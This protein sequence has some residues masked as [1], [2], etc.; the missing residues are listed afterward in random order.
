MRTSRMIVYSAAAM[1][2]IAFLIAVWPSGDGDGDGTTAASGGTRIVFTRDD[3]FK[4]MAVRVLPGTTIVWRNT[5]RNPHTA[6]ADDMSWDTG[7]LNPGDEWSMTFNEP[8][9]YSYFCAYH[10]A[11]G[12]HGMAGVI[13]VGDVEDEEHEADAFPEPPPPGTGKTIRVPDDAETIQGAVDQAEPG[14]LILVG[15][16]V[17]HEEVTVTTPF[18]TIRGLDRNEVILDGKA[19]LHNGIKVLGAPGVVI[20][21][22]TARYY[23]SNGFYWTGVLGYRGS[24]LT[25]YN[26]GDYGIYAFG[27]VYGQFDNSYASGSPDSGFYIGQCKPCHALITDVIAEHNALGYSG[28]NAG[29]NLTIMNSVWRYN[30]SGIVPNTLDSQRLA[31]QDGTRIV[32]NDIYSNHNEEAPTFPLQYPSFGNGIVLTG[33]INNVVEGN[34]IWD[35]PNYGIL[36]VPNIDEHFWVSSGHTIRANTLWDSGKADLAMALPTGADTCFEENRHTSSLPG[37][38]EAVYSCGAP[39][40]KLGGGDPAVTLFMLSQFYKATQGNYPSGDWRTAPVPPPQ[41]NMPDVFAA[42]APAWPTPESEQLPDYIAAAPDPPAEHM[43]KAPALR[44][45]GSLV[46]EFA[47]WVLPYVLYC[48]VLVL[49]IVSV[50]RRPLHWVKKAVWI[51]AMIALPVIGLLLYVLLSRWPVYRLF[52]RT[53]S[54]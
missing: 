26:N 12:G 28:T 41:P 3:V 37:G 7:H 32:N 9:R 30:M 39:L 45:G 2:V 14:D 4:E 52:R 15:P 42:P 43:S 16:G 29:G 24:Y 50:S 13:L 53:R 47:V 27:S 20:E 18:L 19:E 34:R 46:G 31:P 11:P 5:G 25:A 49:G 54:A 22:M 10:G 44:S 33:G 1:A 35:H 21:N 51:V 17:Y 38:L 36:V 6:T 40:T 48:A 23:R 8:G